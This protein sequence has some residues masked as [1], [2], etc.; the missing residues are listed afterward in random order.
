MHQAIGVEKISAIPK[1]Y[2]EDMSA[3]L[4]LVLPCMDNEIAINTYLSDL[5]AK[6][7]ITQSLSDVAIVDD[8]S[9]SMTSEQLMAFAERVVS[10]HDGNIDKAKLAVRNVMDCVPREV[11]DLIDYATDKRKRELISNIKVGLSS[12]LDKSNKITT[13]ASL[14]D[15]LSKLPLELIDRVC[16]AEMRMFQ[17]MPTQEREGLTHKQKTLTSAANY[18]LN[19]YIGFT[20]NSLW[21]AC[22]T[23]ADN[24][25]CAG[26][27]H[28]RDLTPCENTHFGFKDPKWSAETVIA[29]LQYIELFFAIYDNSI[30]DDK[31][32]DMEGTLELYKEALIATSGYF[33]KTREHKA[34][35]LHKKEAIDKIIRFAE[36]FPHLFMASEKLTLEIQREVLYGMPRFS[37]SDY[38]RC[39]SHAVNTEDDHQSMHFIPLIQ[40][41]NF[42]VHERAHDIENDFH[43]SFLKAR[44]SPEHFTLFVEY[45]KMQIVREDI[46]EYSLSTF[47]EFYLDYLWLL[48]NEN[49]DTLFLFNE[50]YSALIDVSDIL[51]VAE[52]I[53]GMEALGYKR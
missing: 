46:D 25:G 21:L 36:S 32:E 6:N 33:L 52:V 34:G 49:S 51:P 41:W 18:Y 44:Y 16:N 14:K 22:F 11:D 48:I 28:H 24:F 38:R 4:M 27:W 39:L 29:N 40:A 10:Y 1:H 3:R 5:F 37:Y 9:P 50:I 35:G 19:H 30:D 8:F 47:S 20:C 15:A 23:H 12:Y 7:D 2:F 13:L 31:K 26:G 43:I 53:E 42:L 45:A 17:S